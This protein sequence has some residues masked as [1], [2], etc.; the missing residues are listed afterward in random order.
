MHTHGC[1]HCSCPSHQLRVNITQHVNVSST[2]QISAD[3]E[4]LA[5]TN[6]YCAWKHTWIHHHHQPFCFCLFPSPRLMVLVPSIS[7]ITFVLQQFQQIYYLLKRDA[8]NEALNGGIT[9][10]SVWGG[11]CH[12]TRPPFPQRHVIVFTV[13]YITVF[14]LIM[15]HDYQIQPLYSFSNYVNWVIHF[16]LHLPSAVHVTLVRVTLSAVSIIERQTKEGASETSQKDMIEMIPIL[17]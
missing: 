6:L 10:V 8:E 5:K 1:L 11:S 7:S 3:L 2:R 15:N 16:A 9:C 17:M 4:T 12:P 14:E 13:T